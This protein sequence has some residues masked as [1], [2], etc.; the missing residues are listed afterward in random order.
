VLALRA[1]PAFEP[2]DEDDLA[3]LAEHARVR[4]FAEGARILTEGQVVQGVHALVDGRVRVARDGRTI[5]DL[6]GTGHIGLISHL[7]EQLAPEALALTDVQTL[8]IPAE[9]ISVSA[10]ERFDIARNSVRLIAAELLARRGQLP[11]SPGGD[12]EPALG[13]HR[14]RSLTLVEKMISIR[15]VPAFANANFDAVAELAKHAQDVRFQPGEVLWKLGDAA[16]WS[17]RID[18]GRVAC[19]NEKGERVV[20]GGGFSLGALDGIA[21]ARRA[22]SATAL[23]EVIGIEIRAAVQL[24]VLEVH[25]T[26]A[27][28]LRKTLATLLV[29][30]VGS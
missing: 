14:P 17:L 3:V 20:V 27:R 29:Q 13:T 18:Y 1:M 10:H 21:G 12:D 30:T 5:A 2:L 26:L 24:A 6:R 15:Q 11:I 22:Y 28:E 4:H 23:T 8:E 16:P 7:A 19:M 9:V 25:P